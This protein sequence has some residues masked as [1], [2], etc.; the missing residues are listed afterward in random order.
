MQH[1]ADSQTN[2]NPSPS[3]AVAVNFE[4]PAKYRCP[5]RTRVLAAVID[6]HHIGCC[7]RQAVS[8]QRNYQCNR[9]HRAMG[10]SSSFTCHCIIYLFVIFLLVCLTA[11]SAQGK[12]GKPVSS[13]GHFTVSAMALTPL[14]AEEMAQQDFQTYCQTE[15]RLVIRHTG[16]DSNVKH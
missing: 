10:R 11:S 14:Y 9:S 16:V 3:Q 12:R 8:M 13:A 15:C 7:M 5:L 1:G 4:Y 2:V 6:K